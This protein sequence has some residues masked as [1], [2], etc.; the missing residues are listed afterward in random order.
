MVSELIVC[1]IGP[2]KATETLRQALAMGADRGVLLT[3]EKRIDQDLQ[4]L[5]VA[6]LLQKVAEKEGAG[7]VLTGKQSIDS[8]SNQVPQMLAG[9]LG[10]PQG[11][12]CSKVTGLECGKKL[13][14]EREVDSGIQKQ[15]LTLPA[16]LSVDLRLNTPRYATLPNLMKAKKKVVEKLVA[17]DVVGVEVLEGRLKV[18]EVRE[19][20][21]R[22]GGV[23]VESVDELVDKLKNE[24][25]VLV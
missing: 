23:K 22:K 1:S 5:A 16:V 8:D 6:K 3:T 14:V 21:A 18:L 11:T 2:E 9:L 20:V 17:A 19:P 24:A 10:W 15:K 7:I 25:K 13:E 12:F 4:P